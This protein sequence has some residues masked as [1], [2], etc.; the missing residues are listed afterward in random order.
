MS[1]W[2]ETLD[3]D[4]YQKRLKEHPL[5][6]RNNGDAVAAAV[7][8]YRNFV[9]RPDDYHAAITEYPY[10]PDDQEVA[11]EIRTYYKD[12]LALEQL[13]S[14]QM[15]RWASET[16]SILI[17]HETLRNRHIGI[18]TRLPFFY[19]E[20]RARQQLTKTYGRLN[21]Q[22]ERPVTEIR[23]LQSRMKVWFM[24]GTEK[25]IEYWFE[26]QNGHPVKWSCYYKNPL[27][28][29]ME[30]LFRRTGPFGINGMFRM[31]GGTFADPGIN[32]WAVI[33]AE[34]L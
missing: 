32:H 26:D 11:N 30:G 8:R 14:G 5:I 1:D 12:K 18:L 34:I 20:D 4:V 29:I 33:T 25:N 3:S 7:A 31:T 2:L 19:Y 6:F 23:Q 13:G 10:G 17:G 9:L 27:K 24:R 22:P 21:L 16:Y 15:S 28:C